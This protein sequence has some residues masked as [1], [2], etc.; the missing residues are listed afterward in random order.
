MISNVASLKD[1][2]RNIAKE[3]NIT[4]QE[5]M[6][7]YMFERI[8]E[9]ISI[10]K[11]KDN[12]ILKGGLL[13]SSIMGIDTRTTMDMDTS[14][15]GLNLKLNEIKGVLEDIFAIDINDNVMFEIAGTEDIRKEDFY[16]G[17][18]FKIIGYF[19]NLKIPL[20]IDISTGD[21]ITPRAL[22]YKYKLLFEDRKINLMA[23][24]NET[25]IA[26]KFQTIVDRGIGNSRMKDYYDIYYFLNHKWKEI[27]K[28]LLRKAIYNTFKNR[29]S[30]DKLE[31]LSKTVSEISD[32]AFLNILWDRYRSMHIYAKGIE[33]KN[34]ILL[35][36]MMIE[37]LELIPQ[38]V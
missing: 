19:E 22:I 15:K 38:A 25:I 36:K 17:Y 31:E 18:R 5:V 32:N 2:S 12:F 37:Q 9:R 8:L 14:I 11:Y 23:Y 26:E 1:K 21:I 3:S 29:D 34:I 13:L 10:S 28:S 35:I 30:L 7:N 27:D 16:G 6:Q 33:F 4:I 20:A 24:N